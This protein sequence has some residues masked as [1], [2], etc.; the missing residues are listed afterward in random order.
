MS[1]AEVDTCKKY[2]LFL[3]NVLFWLVA[4]SL[5]GAGVWAW[6]EKGFFDK[7][8][9]ATSVPFDPVLVVVII[10]SLMFIISFSGCVGSLRES[11]P[12]LKFFSAFLCI[13]FF[14]EIAAGALGFFCKDWL[15]NQFTNFV[16]LTIKDY[17]EDPDL[18]N[19]I[20][21]SQEW[22]QCCGGSSPDDWDQNMYFNCQGKVYVNEIPFQPVE[23]CGVP[24]SCCINDVSTDDVINTQCGYDARKKQSDQINFDDGGIYRMGCVVKFEE[25][26]KVN[27]Y[28]VA[29]VLVGVAVMQIVPICFAQDIIASVELINI[30]NA[31]S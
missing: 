4:V 7:L 6:M 19:I 13:I 23:S 25:W 11:I 21:F 24:Y 15:K 3:F 12:L 31:R 8:A 22:L 26:L 1:V 29:G 16:D 14:L 30:R 18:Q 5:L 27:L 2:F 17:R 9:S 10:A 20:D 28:T